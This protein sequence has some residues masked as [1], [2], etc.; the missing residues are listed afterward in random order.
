MTADYIKLYTNTSTESL[1][2]H[3]DG[4]KEAETFQDVFSSKNISI[5]NKYNFRVLKYTSV[6]FGS[7]Q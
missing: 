7:C 2:Y 3:S 4:V 5:H 6:L 1:F